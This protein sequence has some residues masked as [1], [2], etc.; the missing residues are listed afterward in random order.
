M[1]EQALFDLGAW[2]GNFMHH[3]LYT[4]GA[5]VLVMAV[6]WITRKFKPIQEFALPVLDETRDGI[7]KAIRS[8]LNAEDPTS[9]DKRLA[10]QAVVAGAILCGLVIMAM[11]TLL[12]NLAT[13][14]G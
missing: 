3:A 4:G 2:W 12:A 5:L 6:T 14:V 10:G 13:P 7:A 9:D 11:Y 1:N 8:Y